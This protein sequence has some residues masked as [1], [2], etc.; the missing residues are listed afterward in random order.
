MDFEVVRWA[1][2]SWIRL[3]ISEEYM[4]NIFKVLSSLQRE[5]EVLSRAEE[6]CKERWR[7]L[8]YCVGRR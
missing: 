7:E 3:G 2:L 6:K 5:G 8:A 1:V 4:K